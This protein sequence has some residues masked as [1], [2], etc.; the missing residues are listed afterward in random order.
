MVH[1]VEVWIIIILT[2]KLMNDNDYG[3]GWGWD[4][5]GLHSTM[6]IN[7]KYR[8]WDARI[9]TIYS[10]LDLIRFKFAIFYLFNATDV[11]NTDHYPLDCI[12]SSWGIIIHFALKM[13]KL[14][15][16]ECNWRL[17]KW[18]VSKARAANNYTRTANRHTIVN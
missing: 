3:M 10:L 15:T 6:H 12:C 13:I 11:V 1:F 14:C 18:I 2:C 16:C 8:K 4:G 5:M 17:L 7:V 9:S